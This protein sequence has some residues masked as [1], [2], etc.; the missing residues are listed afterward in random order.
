MS[1]EGKEK[2]H[3]QLLTTDFYNT[4]YLE[5]IMLIYGSAQ[6]Y[7]MRAKERYEKG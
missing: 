4:L 3:A 5:K 7:H 1:A 6:A 2:E